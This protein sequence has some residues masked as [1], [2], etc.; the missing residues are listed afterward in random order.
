[1]MPEKP[2]LYE[3]AALTLWRDYHLYRQSKNINI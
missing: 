3:V 1:M 2:Q